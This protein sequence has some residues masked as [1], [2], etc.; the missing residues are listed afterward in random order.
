MLQ[1]DLGYIFGGDTMGDDAEFYMETGG[2]VY[3]D[4]IIPSYSRK[5]RKTHSSKSKPLQTKPKQKAISTKREKKRNTALFIDGENVSPKKVEKIKKAAQKVG[6]IDESKVYGLQKDEHTR[7]WS[8]KA[9]EEDI[10]D[11]RLSGGPDKDKVDKKI[12]KDAKKVIKNNKSIDV[13]CIA[14]SDRGY[15]DT[16]KELRSQG[17]KV[18]VI[19]EEKAPE[20][21]RDAC[22]EFIEI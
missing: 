2:E 19:G 13:V 15:V 8:E 12:Q 20:E 9:K 7:G 11:I 10:K 21:L 4:W 14:T 17:K 22:S 18:V 16:I 3:E 6:V 5:K 1:F